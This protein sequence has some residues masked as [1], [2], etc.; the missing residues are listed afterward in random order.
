MGR[1]AQM[2][3]RHPRC[4]GSGPDLARA[5]DAVLEGAEL[6]DADRAARVH[7]AGGDADLGAEAELAAIGEL[8]RGVV[9]HDG[10]IDLGEEALGR[11]LVGGDDRV[12]MVRAV[13]LDMVDGAASSPSTTFTAMIRRD[14]RSTSPPRSPASTRAIDSA[15]GGVATH[16]AAGFEQR[17]DERR[18]DAVAAQASSTSSVSAAPQT[19]VRRILAL[20]T[21]SRAM[22]RS[23]R[24]VD[25]DMADAVEMRED[26]HARL[27]LDAG[28]EALAAARHDDVDVAARGPRASRRRRRGRASARAGS[29]RPAGPAGSSPSRRRRRSRSRSGSNPSRR[30]GSRRCRLFRHSAPASAV[31]LGRLSKITPMTPSGVATRSKRRPL[32]RVHSASTRPTGSG[33]AATSATASAMAS[34]RFSSRA[35][36]SMKEA[37]WPRALPSARSLRIGGED[38]ALRARSACGHRRCRAALRCAAGARRDPARGG[39]GAPAELM[40]DARRH[41]RPRSSRRCATRCRPSCHPAQTRHQPVRTLRPAE[42]HVVPVDHLGAA[43]IAEHRLDVARGLAE[44]ERRLAA[45]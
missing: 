9:E 25:I 23:A 27:A 12:G 37:L 40:H 36:R 20:S 29:R 7:A 22:A 4:I 11:G 10:G 44:N 17:L 21:M 16:R 1:Q 6:L 5:V 2:L 14:I 34:R 18:A 39:A 24:G 3:V 41:R 45:S 35:R 8:G 31:T 42:R 13:A 30:A 38:A 15:C 28:D 33:R 19:P 43:G 32:G 26:R